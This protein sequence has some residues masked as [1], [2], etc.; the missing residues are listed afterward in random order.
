[1]SR[2]SI[3][4]TK[5]PEIRITSGTEEVI[6][7]IRFAGQAHPP[8]SLSLNLHFSQWPRQKGA[9]VQRI[10]RVCLVSQAAP[11]VAV[12]I[13]YPVDFLMGGVSAVGHAVFICF[14][15]PDALD[16]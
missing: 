3:L 13:L 7:V 12:L 15:C 16:L 2:G 8:L 9:R 1:M 14:Q 6:S 5:I 4:I 10:L 11:Y